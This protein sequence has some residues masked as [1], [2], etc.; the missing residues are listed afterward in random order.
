MGT[1][2]SSK[3][4]RRQR[5]EMLQKLALLG[6]TKNKPSAQAVWQMQH[7]AYGGPSGKVG[8]NGE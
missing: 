5:K 1:R 7:A 4:K 8:E 6:T 3:E 2:L